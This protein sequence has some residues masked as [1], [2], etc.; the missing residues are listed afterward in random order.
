MPFFRRVKVRPD[1]FYKKCIDALA[2]QDMYCPSDLTDVTDMDLFRGLLMSS[3]ATVG[4]VNFLELAVVMAKQDSRRTSHAQASPDCPAE[5]VPA[6]STV[7]PVSASSAAAAAHTVMPVSTNSSAMPAALKVRS[8]EEEALK[9]WRRLRGMA[10]WDIQHSPDQY[11]ILDVPNEARAFSSALHFFDGQVFDNS[12]LESPIAW[13]PGPRFREHGL[14]EYIVLDAGTPRLIGGVVISG[15]G[16]CS[17]HASQVRLSVSLHGGP[18]EAGAWIECGDH[19]CCKNYPPGHPGDPGHPGGQSHYDVLKIE[20]ARAQ[21]VKINPREW[22]EG[23]NHAA[24]RC[25][26]LIIKETLVVTLVFAEHGVT[27]T[28]LAGEIIL[29]MAFSDDTTLAEISSSVKAITKHDGP[30]RLIGVD[31]TLLDGSLDSEV[32][33]MPDLQDSAAVPISASSVAAAA[34]SAMPV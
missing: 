20:P 26:L 16:C 17:A 9:V 3:N 25:A 28:N 23:E 24:L 27:A 18:H 13:A 15:C 12:R 34:S 1:D 10:L 33:G 14:N 21:F 22:R 8:R 29:E 31:G 19:D 7:M 30:V 5:V 4:M 6:S 2:S 11:E 32:M